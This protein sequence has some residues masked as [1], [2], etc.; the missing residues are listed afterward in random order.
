MVEQ[1]WDFGILH[2]HTHIHMNIFINTLA[3]F[4][5]GICIAT[6]NNDFYSRTEKKSSILISIALTLHIQ[7]YILYFDII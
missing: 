5:L 3:S 2:M 1:N 6:G 4:L 7:S